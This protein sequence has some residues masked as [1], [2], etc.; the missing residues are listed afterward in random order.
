MGNR[1]K[2]GGGSRA[3]DPVAL[4]KAQLIEQG[5]KAAGD[6]MHFGKFADAERV[7]RGILDHDP[8]NAACFYNMG[9]LCRLL[10]RTAEAENW[11][12]KALAVN[13]A[14]SDALSVL[15]TLLLGQGKVEE[16]LKTSAR[17][18]EHNPSAT[19]LT[20]HGSVLM[21]MGKVAE[22]AEFFRRALKKD[23]DHVAAYYDTTVARKMNAGDPEIDHMLRLE[24]SMQA[25]DGESAIQLKFAL[26][27]AFFD[28]KDF[29]AS[30]ARYAEGNALKKRLY[31][32][33]PAQIEEFMQNMRN[34]FTKDFVARLAGKGDPSRRPIFII[35]MPRSGTTLTE[36]ILASHPDV[37][38]ADELK[39][40]H[41]ALGAQADIVLPDL[42][43]GE[44]PAAGT[45]SLADKCLTPGFMKDVGARYIASISSLGEGK[46]RL[47]DKMPFNFIWT[48]F[49]RLALPNSKIVHCTRD[50][51]DI[52]LSVWRQNFTG[53]IPWAYDQKDIAAYYHSYK[54]MMDFWQDLFPGEIFEAN[55][56]AIVADQ[57][58]QSRRLLEFCELPWD[59]RCLNFHKSE[60][61]V[62][63]ASLAQVRQPI[64]RDSVKAWK[65]FEP[66][67]AQM[68]AALGPL[69]K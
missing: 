56:E 23:P 2:H 33:H 44:T 11:V 51:V 41:E 45:A 19:T 68:I 35:G 27:K 4:Q 66:H 30:F 28:I 54:R 16:A 14:D 62:K 26:G 47:T 59:E 48:G 32:F 49:I 69:I 38:G 1:Q 46:P 5:L 13:P 9:A 63:T 18:V 40:F 7:Y 29:D 21:E 25:L 50:P 55:Y 36:Q 65:K 22:A 24:K 53:V 57:E 3:V 15:A 43:G 52:G 31:A 34:I 42:R 6:L 10:G 8:M 20:N 17:S 61:Q 60:R 39:N 12:R 37:F 67:L 64:Y 58:G